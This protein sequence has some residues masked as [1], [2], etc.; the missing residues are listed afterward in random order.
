MPDLPR[1]KLQLIPLVFRLCAWM[2]VFVLALILIFL[3]VQSLPA[4]FDIGLAHLIGGDVWKPSSGQFGLLP[5]I[6]G[7]L[8]VSALALAIGAPLGLFTA[9]FLAFFCPKL[10]KPV[11]RT[12][13]SL[14]AGIPSVVYG[15]F[16]LNLIVPFLRQ[17]TGSGMSLLAAGVLLGIMILPTIAELSL[18]CLENVPSSC[19]EGSLA[20]GTS[21]VY[22]VFKSVLPAAK[23]GVLSAAVLGLGRAVGETMAVMMIAGNQA[24]FPQSLLSGVRTLT[25]N[26]ALEMGYASGLHRQALIA[27]ALVLL[28]LVMLLFLV[29]SFFEKK[30][31][32]K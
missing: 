26:I 4:F 15:L 27:S 14:M 7:S 18:S 8:C 16:G 2:C 25:A 31:N 29:R 3:I 30:E 28:V 10:C 12:V 1:Q 9:M 5:M 22:A 19:L 32:S 13:I 11:L 21:R 17:S 20:L 6:V 24:I 23:S